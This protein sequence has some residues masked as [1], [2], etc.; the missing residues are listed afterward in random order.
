MSI[1]VFKPVCFCDHF[2]HSVDRAFQSP[3]KI[4]QEEGSLVA[5]GKTG[6]AVATVFVVGFLWHLGVAS[7]D[8]W[9]F[10][11][12]T[13]VLI[14]NVNIYR[15]MKNIDLSRNPKIIGGKMGCYGVRLASDGLVLSVVVRDFPGT[16]SLTFSIR[17][18]KN[19]SIWIANRKDGVC[20][21][22]SICSDL[23]NR[24]VFRDYAQAAAQL[25]MYPIVWET[26]P[27]QFRECT[28]KPSLIIAKTGDLFIM[29]P[30][31]ADFPHGQIIRK[32]GEDRR[33]APIVENLNI[34]RLK[35]EYKKNPKIA[36]GAFINLWD[37]KMAK[38]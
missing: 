20:A 1:S 12:A 38:A 18:E 25:S 28:P 8:T 23:Y 30:K 15:L 26:T 27:Y 17:K 4:S 19:Q 31:T 33:G 14:H 5:A 37:E 36:M 24:I 34:N 7:V 22:D 29:W 16:I 32:T 21:G 6:L 9:K 2:K 13:R 35:Y 10:R 11:K 3:C